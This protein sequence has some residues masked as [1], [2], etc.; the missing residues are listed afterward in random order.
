LRLTAIA[1]EVATDFRSERRE[2][3]LAQ[4]ERGSS[5]TAPPSGLASIDVLPGEQRECKRGHHESDH[6]AA[7]RPAEPACG[8]RVRAEAR[9]TT[10]KISAH[11]PQPGTQNTGGDGGDEVPSVGAEP[12]LL[13]TTSGQRQG[14]NM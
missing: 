13:C 2:H 1:Q 8:R 5:S 4:P 11:H 9:I 6:H 7:P 14:V 10:A 3:P 12:R